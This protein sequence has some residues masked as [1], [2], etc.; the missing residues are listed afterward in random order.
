MQHVKFPKRGVAGFTLGFGVLT[1]L[2]PG[3][4]G[5]EEPSIITTANSSPWQIS[6][7][8]YLW[9]PK[10]QS[11]INV[12]ITGTQATFGLNAN[13]ILNHLNLAAMG[14]FD[15]H[16]QR[17][18]FFT[19]VV[20]MSLGASHSGYRN[21]TVGGDQSIPASTSVYLNLNF[22]STIVTSALEY[23]IAEAPAEGPGVTMDFLAG[24]R[25]FKI[26]P[27]LGWAFSGSIGDL[28]PASRSGNSS[29]SVDHW[30]AIVGFK[31]QFELGQGW[32]IPAY[33]DIGGCLT[34]QIATGIAYHFHWGEVS[35]LYRYLDYNLNDK[36]VTTVSIGGPML[37]GTFRW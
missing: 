21:F 22:K 30:D 20:Y 25:Y 28:P 9:L 2:V 19:D 13:D 5:A 17:F 24:T 8:P 15:V 7:T 32:A 27:T 37:G 14:T 36:L 33:A 12:P 4:A 29:P 10:I 6:V 31:G 35:A 11:T 18:G 1:T 34:W 23:R 3:L 16:Y 26:N